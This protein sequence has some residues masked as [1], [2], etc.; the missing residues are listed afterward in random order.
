MCKFHKDVA[1]EIATNEAGQFDAGKYATALVS[2][3]L[4]RVEQYMP[5]MHGC[6]GFNPAL[7]ITKTAKEALASSGLGR[8]QAEIQS[9]LSENMAQL[10]SAMDCT[11]ASMPLTLADLNIPDRIVRRL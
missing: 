1:R 4:F 7:M 11:A 6:D 9:Y 5:S 3:A 2:M 8:S 10:R